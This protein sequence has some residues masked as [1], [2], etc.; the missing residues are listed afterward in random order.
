MKYNSSAVAEVAEMMRG[1]G[2]NTVCREADCPN[3]GECYSRRTA[4][5]MVLG[6][7]CTRDCRFCNVTHGMP[8]PPDPGEPAAIA[9]AVKK[10]RLRHAVI[11]TVTRDDL[12]DGGASH[13]AA[14]IREIR[15]TTPDVTIEVLVSDMK[16]DSDAF[17]TVLEACPDVLGHNVETVSR[18]YGEV[19]PGADYERSL[20]LLR[21]AKKKRPDIYVKTG[22]MVGL[23]ETEDEI[24]SLLR[25]IR[26]TGCDIV[27]IGQY[28]RPSGDHAPLVR[29]VTPEQF[30]EY[31][32][33]AKELGFSGVV[34]SPLARSSYHAAES[35]SEAAGAI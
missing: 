4:T 25:D 22:F 8:T 18:L 34:S 27:T 29:Y 1:L 35:F 6:D 10:L 15:D 33:W 26:D 3:I 9:E 13:F 14:L 24:R 23:G 20:G 32:K 21:Y 11:T 31:G 28:L 2:L 19:R 12:P 30:E 5:F 17:D 7:R 16:G